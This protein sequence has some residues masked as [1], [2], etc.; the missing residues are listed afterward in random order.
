[1]SAEEFIAFARELLDAAKKA[2]QT[3]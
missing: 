3:A 2:D 1:M